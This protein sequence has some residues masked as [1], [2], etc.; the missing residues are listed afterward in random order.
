M[1]DRHNAQ[2]VHEPTG[3]PEVLE[4]TAA[5]LR[6]DLRAL[7]ILAYTLELPDNIQRDAFIDKLTEYA[8]EVQDRTGG[9][10]LAFSL[11]DYNAA[12]DPAGGAFDPAA[13]RQAIDDAGGWQVFKKELKNREDLRDFY[14]KYKEIGKAAAEALKNTPAMRAAADLAK[15]PGLKAAT[16]LAV[17]QAHILQKALRDFL[18]SPE[19][20]K[21][22][23]SLAEVIKN[24][25]AIAAE[26]KAKAAEQWPEYADA[27]EQIQEIAIY[28]QAELTDAEAEGRG[29][30]GATLASIMEASF[31]EKWKPIK[32]SP[33]YDKV[34]SNAIERAKA[35][36]DALKEAE[37]LARSEEP[38]DAKKL[39]RA[40]VEVLGKTF[41][42]LDKGTRAVYDNDTRDDKL[43]GQLV[44]AADVGKSKSAEVVNYIIDF[45]KMQADGLVPKS[46]NLYD[47]DVAAA[48]HT[49]V[50]EDKKNGR[51]ENGYTIL[52]PSAIYKQTGGKELHK[53]D[54]ENIIKSCR[55][56][57]YTPYK[58]ERY[59]K[60]TDGEIEITTDYEGH[61]IEGHLESAYINGQYV[62]TALFVSSVPMLEKTLG[63]PGQITR[64]ER[65]LLTTKGVNRSERNL[66]IRNYL[67][68]QIKYMKHNPE[69]SRTFLHETFFENCK[70]PARKKSEALN[71]AR[72]ILN[73][74]IEQEEIAGYKEEKDRFTI[75]FDE[76]KAPQNREG[77][78]LESQ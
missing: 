63:Q 77:Q 35:R 54:R 52:S 29:L 26:Q 37:A 65:S 43:P 76:K 23:E 56:Q 68:R 78:N 13:Y 48:V 45:D 38:K 58:A 55:K 5:A 33:Y 11:P 14:G 57:L 49:L 1:S 20:Q 27:P 51:K 44:L 17:K 74:C 50:E 19:M 47:L 66:R 61:F 24:V 36:A 15:N 31:T 32:T 28:I 75:L 21:N 71:I 41:F 10:Q 64:V 30:E 3:A 18:N 40:T 9:E 42:P 72:K 73:N 12:L 59:R 8:Q 69:F 62:E 53:T 25:E 60:V 16:E 39:E 34:V 46:L 2:E 22:R 67:L 70:V 7:D 4:L 6:R